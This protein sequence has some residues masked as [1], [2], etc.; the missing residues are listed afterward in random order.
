MAIFDLLLD[1]TLNLSETKDFTKLFDPMFEALNA[2]PDDYDWD[3]PD[4]D[5]INDLE[6]VKVII[7]GNLVYAAQDVDI[8]PMHMDANDFCFE[9]GIT[10]DI[11]S[12]SEEEAEEIKEALEI[13]EDKTGITVTIE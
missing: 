9:D 5:A 6:S 11:S 7:A 8:F 10:F 4:P 3:M 13:F 1:Q 2:D 12:Y